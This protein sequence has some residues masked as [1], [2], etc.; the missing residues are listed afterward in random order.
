MF[1]SVELAQSLKQLGVMTRRFKTGT[2]PRINRRSV[3][4]E[5]LEPQ[6]GD[7]KITHFSYRK[8]IE[9]R[10]TNLAI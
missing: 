6:Y 4:I 2:P 3:D 8:D 7:E 10:N 1:P 5:N 9:V